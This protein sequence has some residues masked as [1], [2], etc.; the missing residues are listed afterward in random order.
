MKWSICDSIAL[1]SAPESTILE[2]NLAEPGL[3]LQSPVEQEEVKTAG[4]SSNTM[5]H[6][7]VSCC[8]AA[9]L[10]YPPK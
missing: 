3:H 1:S 6:T 5:P 4:D 7:G 10:Q 8:C 9:K 2:V